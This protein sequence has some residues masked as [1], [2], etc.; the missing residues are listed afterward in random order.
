MS[1]CLQGVDKFLGGQLCFLLELE[2]A[3]SFD[4]PPSSAWQNWYPN[5]DGDVVVVSDC[6]WKWTKKCEV[7][8]LCCQERISSWD[9][10]FL[11]VM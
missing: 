5:Y 3:T 6:S 2:H 11:G 10:H 4:D 8:V 7:E 1:W 9:V